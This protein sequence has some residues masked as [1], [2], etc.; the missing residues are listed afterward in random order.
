M[1][2]ITKKFTLNSSWFSGETE[3]L[4]YTLEELM[5]TKL[6]ALYQRSKGRDLFDLWYALNQNHLEVSNIL[7]VFHHYMD[8]QGLSVS[9][10]QFEKNLAEKI[11]SK[12]FLEDIPSLLREDVAPH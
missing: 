3:I 11:Q 6:R 10:A 5:G 2:L 8:Q 1:G 7:N 4:T 12:V 9:R